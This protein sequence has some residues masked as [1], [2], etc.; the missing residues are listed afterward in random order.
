MQI[1]LKFL[2]VLYAVVALSFNMKAQEQTTPPTM[3]EPQSLPYI[4]DFS[5]FTG[6][7]S[8]FPTSWQGWVVAKAIPSGKGRINIPL[9][10]YKL[11][12]GTAASSKTGFYDFGGKIGFLSS[13]TDLALCLA[14]NTTG[15][16]NVK[17]TFD[18]MSMRNLYDGVSNSSGFQYG[19]MLQY[20]VGTESI[21][22][23]L[24]YMPS[25]YTTGSI[26]QTS[27]KEG[28]NVV[29][30]LSATLPASCNNQAIVQIRWVAKN[31][32]GEKPGERPS[33]AIDNVSVK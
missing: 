8:T 24:D 9:T 10:D 27:G 29:T 30:G 1:N 23:N 17:V 21:F 13:G 2:T 16:E 15:K 19:L 26:V 22:S 5:S 4:Q 33:F 6:K 25:M 20:R 14:I 18:A 7:T 11:G 3:P 12:G 32:R 28:L 31:I